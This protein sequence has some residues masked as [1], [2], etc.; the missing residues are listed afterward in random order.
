M[1][2]T[3]KQKIQI[4]AADNIETV[5]MKTNQYEEAISFR[6]EE[7]LNSVQEKDFEAVAASNTKI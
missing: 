5:L 3:T 2:N 7:R 4:K 1:S 6:K